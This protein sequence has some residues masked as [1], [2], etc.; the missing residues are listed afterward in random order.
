MVKPNF[1]SRARRKKIIMAN[2]QI[3]QRL[4]NT[5]VN[6]VTSKE[7]LGKLIRKEFDST[8]DEDTA[9]NLL[10]LAFK[11]NLPGFPEMLEDYS[12]TDFKWFV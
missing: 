9:F 1:N 2:I 11:W 4:V 10:F 12:I 3:L 7:F 8:Q 5:N 6:D